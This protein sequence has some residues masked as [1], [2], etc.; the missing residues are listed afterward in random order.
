MMG[1]YQHNFFTKRIL[2]QDNYHI[3][4]YL[5]YRIT[6]LGKLRK[7]RKLEHH[8]QLTLPFRIYIKIFLILEYQFNFYNVNLLPL[9]IRKFKS[10]V[11]N[12]PTFIISTLIQISWE[13]NSKVRTSMCQ[14]EF[15]WNNHFMPSSMTCCFNTTDLCSFFDLESIY[16]KYILI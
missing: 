14:S 1:I 12:S 3:W 11:S 5:Y 13:I 4:N 9:N 16:K 7:V 10:E 6:R 15:D 2:E 8:F